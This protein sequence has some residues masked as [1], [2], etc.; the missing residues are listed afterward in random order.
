MSAERLGVQRRGRRRGH[1]LMLHPKSLRRHRLQRP[2]SQQSCARLPPMRNLT[3]VMMSRLVLAS[4]WCCACLASCRAGD[5]CHHSCPVGSFTVTVPEDRL[6]DVASVEVTGPCSPQTVSGG[7]PQV[8]FFSVT[9]EGVCQVTVS[10]RSGAP[11]FVK[12]VLIAKRKEE[13]CLNAAYAQG[14]VTVPEIGPI[15]ASGEDSD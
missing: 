5:D 4:L 12:N 7:V 10:F 3:A 9:D 11:D 2:V 13:C 14:D 8:F 6:S 15:D 1:A